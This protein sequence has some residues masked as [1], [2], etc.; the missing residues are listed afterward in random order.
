MNTSTTS[1]IGKSDNPECQTRPSDF[2][3][4]NSSWSPARARRVEGWIFYWSIR[5][6]QEKIG[7]RSETSARDE[8]KPDVEKSLE[9]V[10][11]EQDRVSEA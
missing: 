7:P 8:V 9:E 10:A 11:A 5:G 3:G 6:S 1:R 4:D 2:L